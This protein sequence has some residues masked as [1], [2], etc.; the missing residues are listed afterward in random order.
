MFGREFLSLFA[1]DEAVIA[2]GLQ[3]TKIMCFSYA[4]SAFMDCSIA[5]CRGI[6]KSLA[7]TVKA[8]DA[9]RFRKGKPR[10]G[11]NSGQRGLRAL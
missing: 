1:N 10:C 4:V 3:R 11:K 9:G 6:G 8:L 7:P 2:A 5:A